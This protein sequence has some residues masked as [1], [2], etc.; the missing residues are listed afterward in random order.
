MDNEKIIK[1]DPETA[2]SWDEIEK[3]AD[4]LSDLNHCL[5]LIDEDTKNLNKLF[6]NINKTHDENC[7]ICQQPIKKGSYFF[8][9]ILDYKILKRHVFH[10]T[11]PIFPNP[12]KGVFI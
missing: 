10:C 11:A 1:A 3:N 2:I 12:D 8:Y 7:D 4:P 6:L 5:D 9:K